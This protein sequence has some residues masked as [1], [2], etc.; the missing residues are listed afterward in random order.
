MAFRIVRHIAQKY[1]SFA[2]G[3]T[4]IDTCVRGEQEISLASIDET[5]KKLQVKKL[6]YAYIYGE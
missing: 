6:M 4:C 1:V 5:T 2:A 3:G